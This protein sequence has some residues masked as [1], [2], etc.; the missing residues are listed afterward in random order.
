MVNEE[1]HRIIKAQRLIGESKNRE[2]R[3]NKFLEGVLNIAEQAKK[4]IA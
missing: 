2:P 4:S 3:L 1:E